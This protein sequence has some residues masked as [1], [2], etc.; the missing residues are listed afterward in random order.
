MYALTNKITATNQRLR[1]NHYAH[2]HSIPAPTLS[3]KHCERPSG[4]PPSSAHQRDLVWFEPLPIWIAAF[5]F[6][7]LLEQRPCFRLIVRPSPRFSLA[8]ILFTVNPRIRTRSQSLNGS[9]LAL[10]DWPRRLFKSL[11]CIAQVCVRS[12]IPISKDFA[13]GCMKFFQYGILHFYVPPKNSIGAQ[14]NI[15]ESPTSLSSL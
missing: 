9:L 1:G 15:P 5:H 11:L 2:S 10:P 13:P 3:M 7:G 6:P 8:T 12:S 14:T 4:C